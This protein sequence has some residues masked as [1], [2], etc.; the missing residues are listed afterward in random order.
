VVDIDYQ[1]PARLNP[2]LAEVDEADTLETVCRTELE[3]EVVRLRMEGHSDKEVG[4]K[5]GLSKQAVFALRQTLQS[6]YINV[7]R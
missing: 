5:L 1:N 6:R 2:G 3:R 4:L 7:R